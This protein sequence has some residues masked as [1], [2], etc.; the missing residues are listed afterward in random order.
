MLI[1]FQRV[2]EYLFIFS[3]YLFEAAFIALIDV[4]FQVNL[5]S[6]GWRDFSL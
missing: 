1:S 3:G 4:V 6:P 2:H 5:P